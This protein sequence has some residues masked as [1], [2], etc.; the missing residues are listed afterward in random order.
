MITIVANLVAAGDRF[1]PEAFEKEFG[2]AFTRKNEP[3]SIASTGRYRGRAMPY[4]S[5]TLVDDWT[6][7]DE[8]S[9]LGSLVLRADVVAACRRLGADSLTIHLDVEYDE[10]CNFDFSEEVIGA[11]HSLG[12]PLTVSC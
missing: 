4:G 1:S 11:I 7:C 8:R 3:G 9:L 10:Q 6:G 2:I 12:V 5:G